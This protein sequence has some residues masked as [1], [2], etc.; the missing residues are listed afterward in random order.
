MPESVHLTLDKLITFRCTTKSLT[1]VNG[2][3]YYV[4]YG[5]RHNIC[6]VHTRQIVLPF[7]QRSIAASRRTSNSPFGKTGTT[8]RGLQVQKQNSISTLW[9][10]I[11]QWPSHWA[12]FKSALYIPVDHVIQFGQVCVGE[13]RL[14]LLLLQLAC[15][16]SLDLLIWRTHWRVLIGRCGSG[17][18]GQTLSYKIQ[19]IYSNK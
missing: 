13:S 10:W 3:F 9:S 17:C 16:V 1:I 18:L 12:G 7:L 5:A 2:L 4:Q 14:L 19:A 15:T 11:E 6:N 8:Q